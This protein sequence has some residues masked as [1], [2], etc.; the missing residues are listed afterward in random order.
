MTGKADFSPEE[1]QTIIEGAAGSGMLVVTASKG[2]TI[3]ETF[4]MA[5]A[6]A[7]ARR[8]HGQSELLD[9]LAAT[10]PKVDRSQAGS[11]EELR[12]HVLQQLRDAVAL[13]EA[14]AGGEEVAAYRGF[15]LG[16]TERVAAA[17]QE[18]G[19]DVSEAERAVIAEI[20]QALGAGS[21]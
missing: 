15:V 5:K 12:L 8:Q 20:E 18:D 16:L 7:E 10:R 14:K 6:Y 1:W 19:A 4:S 17:H 2:G 21:D 13:L 11:S 9:E 3:R